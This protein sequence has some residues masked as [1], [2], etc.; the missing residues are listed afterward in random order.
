C[1]F[2][3]LT[4]GFTIDIIKTLPT[5]T[6]EDVQNEVKARIKQLGSNGGYVMASSHH[7]QADTPLENVEAM[8]NLS[9]R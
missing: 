3:V 4:M 2:V 7:I 8:Y 6:P 9:I 5:G 1:Q